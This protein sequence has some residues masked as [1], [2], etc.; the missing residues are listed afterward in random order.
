MKTLQYVKNKIILIVAVPLLV[1]FL[2]H[3]RAA[4]AP[5]KTSSSPSESLHTAIGLSGVFSQREMSP[6]VTYTQFAPEVVGYGYL[7]LTDRFWMRPGMR[8]SYAWLQPAMAQSLK[9]NEYDFKTTAEMGIVWSA[10]VIPSLSVG[11]GA[12][13]R[14]TSLES[15]API[16]NHSSMGGKSILPVVH[17]QLGVGIPIEKGFIVVEPYIRKLFILNDSRYPWATGTE[18]TV[19][20]F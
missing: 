20:L 17:A 11:M 4:E 8:L 2:P 7:H 5:A 12:I 14:S 9:F 19:S 15:S 1:G 3:A 16:E 6:Q 13:Y 18:L 10:A